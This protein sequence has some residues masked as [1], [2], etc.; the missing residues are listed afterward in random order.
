MNNTTNHKVLGIGNA[1]TDM[2]CV[3]PSDDLI[4][5]IG[6]PRGSMQL[7][8]A[9]MLNQLIDHLKNFSVKRVRGGSAPNTLGGIRRLGLSAGFIGKL[10]QDSTGQF[11]EE[12]LRRRDIFTHIVYSDN[13]PSGACVSLVSPDGERTMLTCLGAA[14][15]L[16][17]SDLSPEMFEGYYITHID[18]YLL[19]NYDLVSRA[20]ALAH[21]AGSLVSVDMGS[22]NVVQENL[23]FLQSLMADKVDV[24]F[25]NEEEAKTYSGKSPREA[26]DVLAQTVSY[27]VVKLGGKGS[28]VKHG[29]DYRFIE[30]LRGVKCVDTTGAGDLYASGFLYG[31]ATDR[32]VEECGRIGALVSGNVVEVVGT[33]IPD[34]RWTRILKTL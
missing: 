7:V 11:F 29:N 16:S 25:A 17:A 27:S 33:R 20:V 3:L 8:S 13:L 1:L 19:Q 30:P 15:Q 10:G 4:H 9:P 18:G 23:P 5:T 32:P 22:F 6:I 2:L 26:L 28:M 14:G 24:V 12:D 21:Q 34:E 31:L